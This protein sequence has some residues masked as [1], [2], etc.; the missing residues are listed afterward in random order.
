MAC[1]LCSAV[2][3]S[4][5]SINMVVV[6]VV[7]VMVVVVVVVVVVVMVVVVVVILQQLEWCTLQQCWMRMKNTCCSASLDASSP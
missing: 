5:H 4:Y 2:H 6:V 7:V 3:C 1:T